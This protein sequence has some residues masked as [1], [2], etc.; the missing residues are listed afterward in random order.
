MSTE[1]VLYAQVV[2]L[3]QKDFKITEANKNKNEARFRLQCQSVRSQRWFNIDFDCIE[4]SF[5]TREPDFYRKIFQRNDDTKGTNT[6]KFFQVPIG[7]VKCVEKLSFAVMPQCS[8]FVKS[9]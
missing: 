3:C 8:S 6:F 5:S 1:Q 2:M 7:N 9:H 4:V